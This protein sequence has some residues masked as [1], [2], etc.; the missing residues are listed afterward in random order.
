MKYLG[1]ISTSKSV[2][3]IILIKKKKKNYLKEEKE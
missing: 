3:K 2:I 1:V